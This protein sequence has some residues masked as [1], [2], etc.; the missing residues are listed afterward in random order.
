MLH[1][2]RDDLPALALNVLERQEAQA[3]RAHLAHC[4]QCRAL[5]RV[6]AT[7]V[8]LLPYAALC[9]EPPA[10]LKRRLLARLA[11]ERAGAAATGHRCRGELSR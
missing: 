6:Y 3:I 4:A 9:Q 2:H 11:S 5:A 7:V 10:G 1:P 8:T